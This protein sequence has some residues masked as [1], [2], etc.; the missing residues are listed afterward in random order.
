MAKTSPH[1]LFYKG[2][3]NDFVIFI[4]NADLLAKYKREFSSKGSSTIPIID[5]VSIFKVFINR[6]RGAEGILDEAAKSDLEN[7]FKTSNADQVIK[8]ILEKGEDKSNTGAIGEIG[9]SHND[10]IGNGDAAN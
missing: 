6:Q 1:K 4:D 5:L 8:I 9:G 2:A 10:S 7:E 3:E